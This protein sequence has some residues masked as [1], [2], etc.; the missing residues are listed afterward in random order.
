MPARSFTK[1]INF[2]HPDRAVQDRV[3]TTAQWPV[4]YYQRVF[5]AYPVREQKV[6]TFAS[7]GPTINEMHWINARH[8]LQSYQAGRD[9]LAHVEDNLQIPSGLTRLRHDHG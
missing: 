8:I 3:M 7:M 6:A 4:P 5:K 1:L 2:P 9:T